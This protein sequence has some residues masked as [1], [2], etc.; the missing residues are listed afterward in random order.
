MLSIK[1][2]AQL[3]IQGSIFIKAFTKAGRS[4]SSY[5]LVSLLLQ[6]TLVVPQAGHHHRGLIKT[7][8]WS[9]PENSDS[10]GL[11]RGS[12]ITNYRW[13][14]W[15][16]RVG[17]P[18]PCVFNRVD[19]FKSVMF[20][21]LESPFLLKMSSVLFKA[22]HCLHE[23]WKGALKAA[24]KLI[25]VQHCLLGCKTPSTPPAPPKTQH[26][27]TLNYGCMSALGKFLGCPGSRASF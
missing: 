26:Q 8:P 15:I 22:L 18:G 4:I 3:K 2:E 21:A 27:E 9:I 1:C 25:Q 5:F 7:L 24:Q 12:F 6:S 17:N 23:D 14:R 16:G 13:V 10:V 11:G 20:T 19:R